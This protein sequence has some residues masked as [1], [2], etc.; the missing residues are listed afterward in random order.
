LPATLPGDRRVDTTVR[1]NGNDVQVTRDGTGVSTD[2]KLDAR[3]VLW[4]AI[5]FL[6]TNDDCQIG[7]RD[8]VSPFCDDLMVFLSLFKPSVCV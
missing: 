5:E 2:V 4:E 3:V 6:D 1:V 8:V 7:E